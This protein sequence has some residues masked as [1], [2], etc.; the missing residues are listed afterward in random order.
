MVEE[1]S[2]IRIYPSK[3]DYDVWAVISYN[4]EAKNRIRMLSAAT[5]CVVI[6]KRSGEDVL[7]L[8]L[9]L[10]DSYLQALAELEADG[11]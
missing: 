1:A 5:P 9:S 4:S 11:E 10:F 7:A 3:L 8:L 6:K 2:E